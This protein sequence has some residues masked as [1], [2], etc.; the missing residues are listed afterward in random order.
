MNWNRAWLALTWLWLGAGAVQA[1]SNPPKLAVLARLDLNGATTVGGLTQGAV[2]EGSGAVY[3]QTW[4]PTNEWGRTYMIEA[5]IVRF[6]WDEFLIQFVAERSG[7]VTLSL[8]G[9]WEEVTP[10]SGSVYKQEVLWDALKATGFSLG[11]AGFES[12]SGGTIVGWSGGV[13]QLGTA[14]VPA[15]DGSR[16]ARSWVNEP[17]TRSFAVTGGATNT[18][19]FF[20]RAATPAG[21]Q[22]MRPIPGRNT[23]AHQTALKFMRGVNFGNY[24]EAPPNT[25]GTIVYTAQDFALARAEGFDHVRLPIAWHHYTGPG[26][27]FTLSNQIFNKVDFLVTNA[28]NQGLGVMVNIHHFDDFTSNPA[29][30]TNKF[31]ALWRQIAARFSNAPRTVVFELL[32]EPNTAATTT[33]LNPIYA[34]AVRQI[35]LTNPE[36]TIFL[37]PGSFNTVGELNYLWLPE[38]ET[39]L[40]VTLHN[41][42]PFLFTHQGASWAGGDAATVGVVFPGPPPVALRP[43]GGLTSWASN[44]F[45]AYNT[46]PTAGNPSGPGAFRGLVHNAKQWSDYFGR[47]VHWG[48][49][50]AFKRADGQSRVNYYCEFRRAAEELGQ[51]WAIWDWKAEFHYMQNNQPNPPGLREALFPRPSLLSTNAGGL[52][53]EAAVGKTFVVERTFHLGLPASWQPVSTQ[54]LTSPHFSFQDPD[55]PGQSRAFYRVQW[56]R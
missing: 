33:V 54:L 17:L 36:R 55:V 28:T 20:A 38:T 7:T 50:G 45:E 51:G 14:A 42:E 15:V 9:H 11:N 13:S 37:G 48:E 56:V 46:I 2:L 31:Y 30:F 16:L 21:F 44:W 47:P 10:G 1:Q 41:Y 4:R 32:N 43:A 8:L 24:L 22:E 53:C 35:R 5:P 49:F 18:L 34:E 39:N 3:R 23:P 29:A 12:V 19:R 52:A 25:W 26:P 40:I 27:A 6:A